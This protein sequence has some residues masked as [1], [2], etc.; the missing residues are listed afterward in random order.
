MSDLHTY[1][2]M[3]EG[4]A[5]GK[6]PRP[7]PPST[8]VSRWFV[9]SFA[10]F[11]LLILAVI[12]FPVVTKDR[13]SRRSITLSNMKQLALATM[14][15]TDD[16]DEHLPPAES[17]MDV[18][19]P[20][21]KNDRIAHDDSIKDRKDDEYGFAF[22]EPVSCINP[23]SVVDQAGVPM[24]FQSV[25]MGRNAHSDLSTLPSIPRNGKMNI[26]AFLDGHAKAFPPTWPEYPITVVIDPSLAKEQEDERQ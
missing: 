18:I 3:Q 13:G 17:W 10:C 5:D 9:A 8:E 25:L 21:H 23:W 1:K 14:M 24:L 15:Y 20:Y 12:L 4:D 26:I 11:V 2:V 19:E 16:N 22:F 7:A 6:Y